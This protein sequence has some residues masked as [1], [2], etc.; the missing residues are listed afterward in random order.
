MGT[1]NL[2]LDDS[3]GDEIQ[4]LS[5]PRREGLLDINKLPANMG[6]AVREDHARVLVR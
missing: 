3:T 5:A 4:N 6:P 1:L 2:W